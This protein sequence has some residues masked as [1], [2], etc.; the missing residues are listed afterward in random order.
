MF[1]SE[2]Q[3]RKISRREAESMLPPMSN[4]QL[5][6]DEALAERVGLMQLVPWQTPD[7]MV[8]DGVERIEIR[9]GVAYEEYNTITVEAYRQHLSDVQRGRYESLAANP[10]AQVALEVLNALLG[11]V[12]L[13]IPVTEDEVQAHILGMMARGEILADSGIA[14]NIQG[15][16]QVVLAL[17]NPSEVTPVWYMLHPELIPQPEEPEDV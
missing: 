2:K 8:K 11:T 13:S 4:K 15:A 17:M 16:W 7:G 3:H 10:K 1:Y 14:G 9:D 6:P 12:G 5:I